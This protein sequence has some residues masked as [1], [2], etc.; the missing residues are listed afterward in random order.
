MKNESKKLYL[1]LALFIAAVILLFSW[2]LFSSFDPPF[3]TTSNSLSLRPGDYQGSAVE[4]DTL[5]FTLNFQQHQELLRAFSLSRP[6]RVGK[7]L[8]P[9]KEFS[10]IYLY[11]FND[12]LP[13]TI[14]P[15]GYQENNLVFMCNEWENG[16][17]FIETTEGKIR[18]SLQKA[19]E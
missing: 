13:L 3:T 16:A 9:V 19:V 8:E 18:S 6:F 4:K 12:P 17:L 11:R 7:P 2:R 1:L 5:P 15:V 10:K 14:E